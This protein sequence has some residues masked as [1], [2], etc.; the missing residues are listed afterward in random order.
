MIDTVCDENGV[1][2][3][4]R[5]I[6]VP[7]KF[8]RHASRS[9]VLTDLG[10]DAE[11]IAESIRTWSGISAEEENTTASVHFLRATGSSGAKGSIFKD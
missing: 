4:V 1:D 9:E 10:M 6:A 2:T 7:Q 11:G 5:I 8:L 3:P